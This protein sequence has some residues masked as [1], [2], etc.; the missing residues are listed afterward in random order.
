MDM[1]VGISVIGGGSRPGL[2]AALL[3]AVVMSVPPAARGQP[4]SSSGGALLPRSYVVSLQLVNQFLPEIV[5]QASSGR[6][7]TAVGNPNATRAVI[8]ANADGSKLATI[9]VDRYRTSSAAAS[10]YQ[11]A[12]AK[13]EAVP[14]VGAI[15]LLLNVG[16]QAF[17]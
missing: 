7:S 16:Q 2:L 17:A 6:D 13:S 8:Y 9:T 11:E 10:A 1:S 15:S 14:G 5:R 12:L 4:A 3:I